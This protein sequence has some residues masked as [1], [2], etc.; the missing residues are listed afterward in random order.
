[1]RTSLNRREF[2]AGS[3]L[4]GIGMGAS[5]GLAKDEPASALPRRVVSDSKDTVPKGKIANLTL[6]RLISGGNLLSG[7]THQRDLLYVSNLAKAYLTEEKQFD[8]LELLEESGVNSMVLDQMQLDLVNRYKRERGG[9]LQT[10]VAVREGWGNWNRPSWNGLR[11]EIK[12]TI[13]QG[14]ATMFL[15]GGY[16][17]RL[18]QSGKTEQVELLGRA[19]D[20]IREQGF[21]AGLGAHALEVPMA[22]DQQ[23]IAP[24]YYFKTFHHDKYWSATPREH[25]KRFCV[26]GPRSINH[27]EFHDNIFCIDPEETI[28]YMLDKDQPWIAFKVLAAGAIQPK[29]AFKYA[30][31]NGV[32]FVAVGMFDFEVA[33]DVRVI[34]EVLRE[35]R[36]ERPW[37]G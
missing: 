8:T 32:D 23:K 22:C 34:K 33:E 18:V 6:S 30:F 11:Q 3:M 14:P 4:A 2:L 21:A 1:M 24:D 31:D 10:L 26:D 16:S 7:W 13:D 37:C 5:E 27:N 19:L 36:R 12:T 35:T 9:K 20:F 15:H 28:E 17:D 25:R 29:S